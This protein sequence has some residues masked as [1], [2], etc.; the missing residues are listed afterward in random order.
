MDRIYAMDARQRH[1]TGYLYELTNGTVY[2]VEL[3]L[4]KTGYWFEPALLMSFVVND[5]LVH[6]IN[7][8]FRHPIFVTRDQVHQLALQRMRKSTDYIVD[9]K[10]QSGYSV[11]LFSGLIVKNHR[12]YDI[13]HLAT[14]TPKPNMRPWVQLELLVASSM[15]DNIVNDELLIIGTYT[16]SEGELLKHASTFLR[17]EVGPSKESVVL[18]LDSNK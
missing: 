5:C 6:A 1:L 3:V 8:L 2:D 4:V 13:S 15:L 11:S 17:M 9:R 12:V 16:N 10:V 7:Y 14:Y 18:H